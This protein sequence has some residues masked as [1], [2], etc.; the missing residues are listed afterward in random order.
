[1]A[2]EIGAIASA[3]ARAA[4]QKI[5]TVTGRLTDTGIVCDRL[6]DGSIVVGHLTRM[7]V[8]KSIQSM[9]NGFDPVGIQVC[10]PTRKSVRPQTCGDAHLFE[11]IQRGILLSM[12]RN[13]SR[14][15]VR[16]SVT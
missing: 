4:D 7:P 12:C 6:M 3:V 13:H 9:K 15:L 16:V 10:S 8:I 1:L 11:S 2:A 14:S 5:A